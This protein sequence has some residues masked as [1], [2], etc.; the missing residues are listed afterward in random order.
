MADIQFEEEQEFSRPDVAP[1]QSVFV[2]FVLST[3][4]VSTQK[5]A[6]YVLFVIAILAIIISVSFFFI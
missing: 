1:Q 4:I 3:G 2:R 5:Q 6:E